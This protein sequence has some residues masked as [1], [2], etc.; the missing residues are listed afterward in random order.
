MQFNRVVKLGDVIH[1]VDVRNKNG[2]VK[3]ELRLTGEKKFELTKSSRIDNTSD[4]IIKK[5]QFAADLIKVTLKG[6][7]LA[8]ALLEEYDEGL[9]SSAYSLFE[10]ND[11]SEVLPQYLMILFRL[12][13]FRHIVWSKTDSSVRGGI[14]WDR[15]CEIEFPLPSI[16]KQREYVAIFSNLLE[17]SKNH[18]KSFKELQKLTDSFMDAM[19][20]KYEMKELG[21]YIEQT[22]KRNRDLGCKKVQGISIQKKFIDSKANMQ[23]VPLNNYKIVEPGDFAYVTV[24]SRNGD[25]ISIALNEMDRCIVSATYITFK[26]NDELL[27]EYLLLWFKRPEFDRYARFNS[28]GSARETF[29]WN[30]MQ[31]VKL[32]VPPLE[33]QKSIVAIHHALEMRKNLNERIKAIIKDIAPVLIKNARDLC[34]V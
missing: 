7:R 16:G 31:R 22:D 8:I 3:R 27:P 14:E 11:E 32:P 12:A 20:Q 13:D 10:V 18:E 28:W 19:A 17:L 33:V 4:K 26:T 23:G 2:V 5:G 34:E 6:D 9:L 30:E 24:T 21:G 29:D 1:R 15:F 25:K